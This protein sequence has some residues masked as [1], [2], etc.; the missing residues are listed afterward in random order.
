MPVTMVFTKQLLLTEKSSITVAAGADK[1]PLETFTVRAT[2]LT[3]I[4]RN[5][6]GYSHDGLN[7]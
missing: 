7:E 1:K 5:I 4:L 2:R 3:E 6:P